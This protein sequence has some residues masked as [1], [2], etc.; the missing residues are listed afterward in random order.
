MSI[1][2]RLVLSILA[3]HLLFLLGLVAWQE[4]KLHAWQTI[5]L[6]VQPVDPVALFRGRYVDLAYD[7]STLETTEAG[8]KEADTVYVRL[9]PGEDGLWRYAGFTRRREPQPGSVLLRGE[10]VTT[11]NRRAQIRT[12]IESYFLSERQAPAI[13]R[14][15][16]VQ[17]EMTVDV[18][19]A[20]DG[21]A[22]LKQLYVEGTR[23]EDFEPQTKREAA[24][25]PPPRREI[26]LADLPP[27]SRTFASFRT[28]G[29][30]ISYPAN[31]NVEN[32]E[33]GSYIRFGFRIAPRE[34]LISGP[35]GVDMALGMEVGSFQ[36]RTKNLSQAT[37]QFVQGLL[38][39]NPGSQRLR[40]EPLPF[41]IGDFRADSV[42]LEGQSPVQNERETV[43]VVTVPRPLGLFYVILVAPRT[44][45]ASLRPLFLRILKSVKFG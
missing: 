26:T 44:Q 3:G 27:P 29:L 8:L 43:W 7:F 37:D 6:R 32:V 21:R 40:G 22:A 15:S 45:L 28:L 12:D 23:A 4:Y 14:L 18:V 2:R 30:E 33:N 10:V 9:K 19:V 17:Y 1:R 24:A 36:T 39:A 25:P 42:L 16:R 34:G 31:W 13:E 35:G 38:R 20:D 41:R 11:W 5:R